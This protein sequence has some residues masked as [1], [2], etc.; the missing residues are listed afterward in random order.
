M[1]IPKFKRRIAA[2]IVF[3]LCLA[4]QIP[5][6]AGI[7]SAP[8]YRVLAP[9]TRGNLTIFPVVAPTSF[10][11][12]NFITL[13][14]G[15][16]SGEVVVTE[17]GRVQPLIR[18]RSIYPPLPVPR[19]GGPQVNQLTLVN[20]SK[21]PLLLLAGEIVTGGKQDRIVGKDR[22][23][24]AD[25]DTDLSVFCVEPGRWTEVSKNFAALSV[26]QMAAPTVRAQAMAKKDQ[27]AVWGAVRESN[28][29][30][31]L[32]TPG[33]A[34]GALSASAAAELQRT[35]SYA[36][37]M[38][39]KEVQRRIETLATPVEH[40][41]ENVIHE[42]RTQNAVG[43]VVAVNGE[44][45]WADLFAS[46]ALLEKYWPK[47]VR[48]YAAEAITNYVGTKSIDQKEAL[49]FLERMEG[50]KEIVESEPGVYRHREVTGTDF[51]LFELASMLPN[52]GFD[53]HISKM[54]TTIP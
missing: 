52:T 7:P 13:D 14:E 39:N 20:N 24:P 33:V 22:I 47:L 4:L 36:R 23:I 17:A 37:V 15:L 42:L 25:S 49:A 43:V 10:D 40:S 3:A 48:S 6:S 51:K 27:A 41:Y 9:I 18:R 1:D 8:H 34:G 30:L 31:A 5:L 50:T 44:V 2:G 19:P 29:K 53:V 26:A 46:T 28:D 32:A 35:T 45:V 11:T 21:H 38:E 12:R 16:R 54:R